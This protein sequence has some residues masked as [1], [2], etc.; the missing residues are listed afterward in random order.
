M[1]LKKWN[2][3]GANSLHQRV[4]FRVKSGLCSNIKFL[5]VFSNI[6]KYEECLVIGCVDGKH[7][8]LQKPTVNEHIYLNIIDYH[9]IYA[10]IICDHTYKILASI[11][12]QYEGAAYDSFVWK[13]Q[14]QTR[15]EFWKNDFSITGKFIGFRN[16]SDGASDAMKSISKQDVSS[17]ELLES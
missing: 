1:C 9:S 4:P 15:E 8:G 10:V 11:N 12:C 3:N 2:R 7:I 17:N 14:N 6:T 13:R 5:E 16:V